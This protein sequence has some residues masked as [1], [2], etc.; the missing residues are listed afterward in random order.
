MAKYKTVPITQAD[1]I[2][3]LNDQSDFSFEIKVLQALIESG[4]SCEHGGTYNDAN[5]NIP[6]QFDIRATKIFGKYFIR[7]AVECKNLRENFPLLISWRGCP[8]QIRTDNGPEFISHRL[9]NWAKERNI[10]I[11]HIQP[12]KPA[13]NAY[14]ERFNRT[15]REDVLDA[16]L[17]SSLREVREIAEHWLEEYNAIRPHEALKGLSPYQYAEQYA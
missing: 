4:F 15:F 16:Y 3:F 1:L 13:Q 10:R 14:I 2:E 5:I 9:A 7:L 6:R 11:T 17:F 8:R 12:G